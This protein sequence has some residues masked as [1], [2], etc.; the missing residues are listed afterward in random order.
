MKLS[1]N[2]LEKKLYS[3]KKEKKKK[4]SFDYLKVL[5]GNM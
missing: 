3:Y 1:Q 2:Q 4:K 5:G